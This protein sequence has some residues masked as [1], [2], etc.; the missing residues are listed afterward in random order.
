MS[1]VLLAC[2]VVISI[3]GMKSAG[4]DWTHYGGGLDR[5]AIGSPGPWLLSPA[6][7]ICPPAMDE[8]LISGGSPIAAGDSAY[9]LVPVVDGNL[10]VAD[11][12]VAVRA[13]DGMRRWATDIEPAAF[14]SW[15]S[16][17]FDV[18][19]QLVLVG[20]GFTL[21][22]LNAADGSIVF[23]TP[24]FH[25]VA[26]ASPLV[27]MNLFKYGKPANR[28]FMSDF[29]FGD[30]TL[31]AINVD[32]F[33]SD[34]NPYQ[35]GEIVWTANLGSAGG[36]TPSYANGKVVIADADG[37]VTA[38][39]A[40][41]GDLRWCTSFSWAQFF[42][43]LSICDDHAYVASYNFGFGANNS[44]LI[45]LDLEDGGVDWI[46]A[47]ERTDSIPIVTKD[48]KIYLSCGYDS[49]GSAVRVQ[50]YRDNG[51]TANRLWD[52]YVGTGGALRVGGWQDQP[53]IVGNF[54]LIGAP[55][56]AGPLAP[57]T[58]LFALD[59]TK[60]P[61]AAGFVKT[62]TTGAGGSVAVTD[63]RAFSIGVDGLSC[64]R[65]YKSPSP[66]LLPTPDSAP[67]SAII[68]DGATPRGVDHVK[69]SRE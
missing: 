40:R 45:K 6:A 25:P 36:S 10:H 51:A 60:T 42:G 59:L 16:P 31:Y 55:A 50:A 22:A 34:A 49:D 19:N 37:D 30:A 23:Q 15:S 13:T 54:L 68:M 39:G 29:D 41:S 58:D 21:Y 33:D 44:A 26:N 27:T 38:Y 32:P 8:S 48:R 2:F 64:F 62:W 28:A 66:I 35:L 57:F 52:T 3:G 43:G 20:S 11:R 47:C 46:T 24:L 63:W 7:W 53:V 61:G 17:A 67:A 18:R 14:D 12:V 5:N 65:L 69:K 9:Y 1:R 4:G 56:P